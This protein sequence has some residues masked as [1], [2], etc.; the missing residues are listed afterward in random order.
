MS[1]PVLINAISDDSSRLTLLAVI[2]PF[3]GLIAGVL[4]L[5]AIG[6]L[7]ARRRAFSEPPIGFKDGMVYDR[8]KDKIIGT[9]TA[10]H[11]DYKTGKRFLGRTSLTYDD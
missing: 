8:K 2:M 3:L 6:H 7:L 4:S 5:I 11:Y 1:D 10:V 9:K